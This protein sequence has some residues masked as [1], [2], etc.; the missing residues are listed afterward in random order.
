MII[1]IVGGVGSGKT[2]SIAKFIQN[3]PYKVYTNFE[4]QNYKNYHRLK[5][6]DIL[7]ED[8]TETKKDGT[9]KKTKLNVNWE[10][11]KK[12]SKQPFDIALDEIQNIAGSRRGM[13][14]RNICINEWTSQIRKILSQNEKNNLYCI[15]QRPLAID[16]H[17]RDL[18]HVWILCEKK[19]IPFN[20]KTTMANK[21]T[22]KLPAT[23]IIQRY[24]KK[25]EHLQT[26][27]DTNGR[28]DLS[29]TKRWFK[30]NDFYR[31]FNSYEMID[32]GGGYL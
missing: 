29:F 27:Q 24:F 3:R 23:F 2:T 16:V 9:P 7:K 17:I 30:A 15:T 8:I 28:Q 31:Y 6:T 32:F 11:W 20:I 19:K 21:T 26:F 18:A 10:Y 5:E 22:K 14:N 4:L 1:I 13:S 25:L 12:Q